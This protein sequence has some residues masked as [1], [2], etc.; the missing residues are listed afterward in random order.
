M[1]KDFYAVYYEASVLFTITSIKSQET[2][3]HQPEIHI[4]IMK[5]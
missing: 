3:Q 2:F 4:A 1:T 5:R